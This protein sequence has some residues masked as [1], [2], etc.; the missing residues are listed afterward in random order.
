M[1][2]SEIVRFVRGL[3][4]PSASFPNVPKRSSWSAFFV[5][6]RRALRQEEA[7]KERIL[8]LEIP[9][10]ETSRGSGFFE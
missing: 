6:I 7:V 2:V 3:P 4:I 5:L 9:Q 8:I 1:Q 10:Q